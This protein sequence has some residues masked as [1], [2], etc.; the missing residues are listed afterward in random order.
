MDLSQ[1]LPSDLYYVYQKMPEKSKEQAKTMDIKDLENILREIK[2]AK[3]LKKQKKRENQDNQNE[4][5]QQMEQQELR[6]KELMLEKE[7]TELENNDMVKMIKMYYDNFIVH[8]SPLTQHELEVKFGTKGKK[9][10]NRIDYDNVIKKLKSNGF[11]HLDNRNSYNLRMQ[12]EYTTSSGYKRISNNR[13]EI[14]DLNTI[15]RY[16]K[17]NDLKQIYDEDADNINKNIVFIEKS[18]YSKDNKRVFPA[19]INDFNFRVTY[20]LEKSLSPGLIMSIVNNWQDNKK[21]FRYINRCSFA[22]E[23]YPFIIDISIV[24]SSTKDKTTNQFKPVY[25]I[26][27]SNVFTNRENYEIEIELDPSKIGPTKKFD[28]YKKIVKSLRKVIKYVLSGIQG[29]NYPISYV[30]QD[31]VQKS[32]MELIWEK[33]SL[34]MNVERSH[35]IGP[36]SVTLQLH[37]VAPIEEGYITNEINIRNDFVVTEKADGLRHLLYINDTGK[38]YL[39]SQG[40]N[41]KFTGC[42]T[43]NKDMYNSLLDGELISHDKNKE[44][45]NLY[46]TFDIYYL[47]NYDTRAFKFIVHE[48]EEDKTQSRYYLL[49]DLIVHLEPVSIVDGISV[50]PLNIVF[51]EFYPFASNSGD[52]FDGC[53]EIISKKKSG[54]FPYETDG[55]IFTH[56]HF[57]VGANKINETGP[58]TNVTWNHSFK[59]KPP[60][61]NTIDFMVSVVKKDGQSKVHT[62]AQEGLLNDSIQY[63]E[64]ILRCGFNESQDGYINPCQ[65]VID[66]N[67]GPFLN[68]ENKSKTLPYQFYPTEPFDMNAG[69]T[70]M[71]LRYDSNNDIVMITEENTVFNDNDIVE[72]YYDLERKPGF[73][74]VPLRVRYDKKFPNKYETAN[75]NWKSIHYPVTEEMVM[76]GANVPKLSI[77]EDKYYNN[78]YSERNY[79]TNQMKDFHNLVVKRPLIQR[80]SNKGDTLIDYACGKAGDMSKW[81]HAK[82][83]FVFGIDVSKDNLENRLNGACARYLN[84]KKKNNDILNALFVNGNSAFN[85][86]NGQGIETEKEKHITNVVFGEGTEMVGPGVEK[87][88]RIGERGFNISSCQFALHY[89]FEDPTLLHGFLTNVAECTKLNGYFIGTAYDGKKIFNM[90]AEKNM[91]ENM[92]IIQDNKKIWEIV[93]E[94]DSYSFRDDS[95]SI[96]YKITVF[97]ESINQYISEY[98][99]NFDYLI[100]L[101]EQYGFKVVD[102]KDAQEMGFPKGIGN[103]EGLYNQ[104]IYD[105]KKNNSRKKEYGTA[106]QMSKNEKQISFLNNYFIFKKVREVNVKNIN[107]DLDDYE[108]PDKDLN[109]SE[110]VNDN[111]NDNDNKNDNENDNKEKKKIV[112]LNKTLKMVPAT[113][114]EVKNKTRTI[115]KKLVLQK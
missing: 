95:S 107:M 56:S 29:T 70:N 66:D 6:E 9:P 84:A 11:K 37:N 88:H 86:R 21:T 47:N 32:Y 55:L 26:K 97:Q 35:F 80:V 24:K 8:T 102:D 105:I 38:I 1:L 109:I 14:N 62:V 112:K 115:K 30:E 48:D 85:I 33:D 76:T 34:H 82:L 50:A 93:K 39:I 3:D 15:Q 19:N 57:G 90:L 22:H 103:F 74:W 40:M 78:D 49:R 45:I 12:S 36:N 79:L 25:D 89:F 61:M 5:L 81:I 100:R 87:N 114:G 77:S 92:K 101:M 41:V 51:K 52:V 104:M 53:S 64:I 18:M 58:K 17:H 27:E 43:K 4:Q 31:A 46:A 69:K 10:L 13:I 7:K 98:L 65:D 67:I 44:F 71:I 73:R 94:Y 91:N 20:N 83:S 23:D 99:I 59:W 72:F 2:K 75:S 42:I 106:F 68:G 63:Q 111:E 113:E 108:N 16:C 110:K 28:S 96:G 54:L 60:E